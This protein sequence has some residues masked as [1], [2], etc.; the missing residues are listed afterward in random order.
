[1]LLLLGRLM[2]TSQELFGIRVSVPGRWQGQ[3]EEWGLG[4]GAAE[5][6]LA[7]SPVLSSLTQL[8]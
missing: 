6:G 3:P 4:V 2:G 8:C 5:R 7:A 1:M